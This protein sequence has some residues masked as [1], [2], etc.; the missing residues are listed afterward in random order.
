MSL[1]WKW[2]HL[3]WISVLSV[4]FCPVLKAMAWQ[5]PVLSLA[6]FRSSWITAC[7]VSSLVFDETESGQWHWSTISIH[8]WC[9][10]MFRPFGQCCEVL[11]M[12]TVQKYF[13]PIIVSCAGCIFCIL[14]W[15]WHGVFMF[16]NTGF[17]WYFVI[18]AVAV[19][20]CLKK[21]CAEWWI[22][23]IL[24]HYENKKIIHDTK[25]F[26]STCAVFGKYYIRRWFLHSFCVICSCLVVTLQANCHFGLA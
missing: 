17:G 5:Q 26:C 4:S 2:D 15:C 7:R 10:I 8:C 3:V 18:T 16:K 13:I 23:S 1:W 20:V 11:T 25:F 19:S 24:L 6:A 12:A 21:N 9:V 14:M 22:F